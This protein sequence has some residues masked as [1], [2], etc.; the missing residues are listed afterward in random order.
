[1]YEWDFDRIKRREFR[2]DRIFKMKHKVRVV[3]RY[4]NALFDL[5]NE[6]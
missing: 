4:L 6:F 1:M 3:R 2:K 5:L